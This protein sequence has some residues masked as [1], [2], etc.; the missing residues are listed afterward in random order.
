MKKKFA[1][2]AS[3]LITA[4]LLGLFGLVIDA[5][6][7]REIKKLREYQA[8]RVTS[9]ELY[10]MLL[11][12]NRACSPHAP[13]QLYIVRDLHFNAEYL[14]GSRF[15]FGMRPGIVVVSSEFDR[16]LTRDQ[17]RTL[18]VHEIVH[19]N[20]DPSIVSPFTLFM[21]VP[22]PEHLA[23]E[24]RTVSCVGPA[25]V[26]DLLM[27]LKRIRTPE[28]LESHKATLSSEEQEALLLLLRDDRDLDDR[29]TLV[30]RILAQR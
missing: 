3:F 28:W 22:W 19:R 10:E 14:F 23:V 29:I 11:E 8:E 13:P 16:L 9:G 4:L 15:P 5:Q 2:F 30:E 6:R 7:E 25:A 12:A 1:I 17:K 27:T 24:S 20:G 26:H 21:S 18:L